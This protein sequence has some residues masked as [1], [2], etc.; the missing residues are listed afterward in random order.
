MT[1]GGVLNGQMS[2]CGGER[3]PVSTVLGEA[4]AKDGAEGH[5]F[6]FENLPKDL[7]GPEIAL[8][9]PGWDLSHEATKL[10]HRAEAMV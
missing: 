8:G 3:S 2:M 5:G 6:A 7:I 1:N 9:P 10:P 4:G